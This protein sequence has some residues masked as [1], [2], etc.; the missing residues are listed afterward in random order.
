MEMKELATVNA[1]KRIRKRGNRS[2]DKWSFS[3]IM[4]VVD[5]NNVP[6]RYCGFTANEVT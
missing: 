4:K 6:P 5:L 1:E 3:R 2:Y